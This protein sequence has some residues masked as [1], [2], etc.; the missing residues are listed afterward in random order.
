MTEEELNDIFS[1]EFY[2]DEKK[3]FPDQKT[4]I[5]NEKVIFFF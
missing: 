5:N 3:W 4:K 2:E 1:P